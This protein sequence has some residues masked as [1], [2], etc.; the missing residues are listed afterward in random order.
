MDLGVADLS[1]ALSRERGDEI[2]GTRWNW[3]RHQKAS[4][5]TESYSTERGSSI[6]FL[7]IG[8]R[9]PLFVKSEGFFLLDREKDSP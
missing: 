1:N 3:V 8:G 6:P 7:K 4:R 2:N 5:Q 9:G